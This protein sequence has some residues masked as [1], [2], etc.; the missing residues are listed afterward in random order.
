MR[1]LWGDHHKRINHSTPCWV[2]KGFEKERCV[3]YLLPG[4]AQLMGAIRQHETELYM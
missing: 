4:R 2:G 1:Q 3:F